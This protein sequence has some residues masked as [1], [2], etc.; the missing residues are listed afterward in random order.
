MRL[1]N[2]RL[3]HFNCISTILN[4][5]CRVL[6]S[7]T[8]AA[9]T[10]KNKKQP[11]QSTTILS[12]F[13]TGA[14]S[15]SKLAPQP[16]QKRRKSAPSPQNHE[17]IVIDSDSEDERVLTKKKKRRLSESSGDIEFVE[18]NVSVAEVSEPYVPFGKPTALLLGST[19]SSVDPS[20]TASFG[21]PFVLLRSL[22]DNIPEND[23]I[24]TSK[25]SFDADE[26]GTGD[27]EVV[28]DEEDLDD[29]VQETLPDTPRRAPTPTS[30]PLRPLSSFGPPKT[31][32]PSTGN[33]AYSILMSSHKE[34]EAWKEATVVEDRNFR[35]SKSN[36]GRRKAPFY[37]ILQGMPIAVDAFKYGSIP[38]VNAYFLTYVDFI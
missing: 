23:S 15:S 5:A 9:G 30:K 37:K 13:S 2:K 24:E 21:K 10:R 6:F 11:S 34:N 38:G 14:S 36:G 33:N 32:V 19:S 18:Q 3:R 31:P 28:Q 17:I 4:F 8:M 25:D 1:T 29:E 35:P 7:T 12:F 20:P 22:K 26:W 27:D 16:K